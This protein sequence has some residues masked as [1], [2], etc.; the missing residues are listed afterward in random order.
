[1]ERQQ[2]PAAHPARPRRHWLM[3]G[4][5]RAGRY[6]Y[7][8]ASCGTAAAILTS[9]AG[10]GSS[11]RPLHPTPA[12]TPRP[13]SADGGGTV[14]AGPP[15]GLRGRV[16]RTAAVLAPYNKARS[17][18]AAAREQGPTP[19]RL[20]PDWRYH[21]S[22][23]KHA[24]LLIVRCM[25]LRDNTSSAGRGEGL[26]LQARSITVSLV[27][28]R[29]MGSSLAVD[30][31]IPPRPRNFFTRLGTRDSFPCAQIRCPA[32]IGLGHVPRTSWGVQRS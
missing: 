21:G 6:P 11:P 23:R 16:R 4:K 15:P 9:A 31:Y 20:V 2:P 28:P 3:G 19:T 7:R 13:Q 32:P 1:M 24:R 29:T 22:G 18:R 14:Q 10:A 25:V 8:N 26:V 17:V 30:P 27:A 5:L 12:T